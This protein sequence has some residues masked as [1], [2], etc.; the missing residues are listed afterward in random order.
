VSYGEVY[1]QLRRA[2]E[3]KGMYREA[4]AA[5]E[6]HR[7]FKRGD[8]PRQ[9]ELLDA[10]M[11]PNAKAYW[12]KILERTKK[13]VENKVEVARFRMVESYTQLGEKEQ[14]LKWLETAYQEHSFWMPFLNVHPHLD[15]LRAEPRFQILARQLGLPD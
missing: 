7:V 10:A 8:A 6:K 5:D 1:S 14:A 2:Y 3:Q 9:V 15:P 4:L 11:V 13:D 12:Q